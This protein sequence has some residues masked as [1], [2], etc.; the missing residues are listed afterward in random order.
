[1]HISKTLGEGAY[2]KVQLATHLLVKEKVA[3][4]T[5]EQSKI[6]EPYAR[7]RVAREIRILK[8]LDHPNII[9]LYEQ[10]RVLRIHGVGSFTDSWSFLPTNPQTPNLDEAKACRHSP[11]PKYCHRSGIVHRDIKL[12]NLLIDEHKNIKIVDFGFSVSFKEG[13]L[14]RKACGSPSYAAPEIV[15]RKPYIPTAIDVWSLGV[16]LYAMVSGYFPFQVPPP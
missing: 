15:S 8:A 11:H 5:F 6:Q 4:K 1:Y 7:K 10:V 2:G 9:R 13:Q 14:L 12:D 16:V 3:V